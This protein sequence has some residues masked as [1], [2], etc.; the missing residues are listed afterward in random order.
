[1]GDLY[2]KLF[3]YVYAILKWVLRQRGEKMRDMSYLKNANNLQSILFLQTHWGAVLIWQTALIH[4]RIFYHYYF[5]YYIVCVI[6]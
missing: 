3:R 5:Y 6:Y 1:V 4:N 2:C